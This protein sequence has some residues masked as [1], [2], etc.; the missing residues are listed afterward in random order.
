MNRSAVATIVAK[1][2]RVLT[3][4][5]SVRISIIAFPLL[6]A[7]GLPMVIVVADSRS[8][9]IP[10]GIVPQLL[11]AFLFFFAVIL[12]GALLPT[13]IAAY[14]L[15]GEK[16]E[17]SLEPLLATPV[18]D[19]EVLLGKAIAALTPPLAAI[20]GSAIVF[21]AF[22]DTLTYTRVGHLY[23]PNPRALLILLVVAPLTAIMCVEFNVL[24]SARVSDVRAAQQLGSLVVLPF[25]AVYV[26][27]ELGLL[28]LDMT[29]LVIMA[30]VIAIVD[31][32]L[33]AASRAVFRR[34][35]ILTTWR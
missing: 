28:T 1:D 31:I 33:Y 17:R 22:C 2:L 29:T 20:W 13:A 7:I 12:G 4:K 18:T 15:V 5:R 6:V 26:A 16:V 9:G 27:T 8:G 19:G 3:T 10:A 25:G 34:E 32:A 21:M 35:E 14:S 11:D 23:F 24:V 30:A